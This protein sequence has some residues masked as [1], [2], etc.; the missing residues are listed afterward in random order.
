M[1]LTKLKTQLIKIGDLRPDKDNRES[2]DIDGLAGSLAQ[3]GL[4]NPIL[5]HRNVIVAGERRWRAA[6]QLKWS[7]IAARVIPDDTP[8]ETVEELRAVENLQRV[9]LSLWQEVDQLD[10]IIST[11][12]TERTL[13]DLATHLGK[14]PTWVAER[15]VLTK[16]LPDL[17]KLA[18]KYQWPAKAIILAA[19]M[20]TAVQSQ[21][22]SDVR[23]NDDLTVKDMQRAIA[24]YM[25]QL[26]TAPWDVNDA[27]LVK[28][29]GACSACPKR[30]SANQVL[31]PDMEKA[32]DDTC[33]D[34]KCWER[35]Q[36]ALIQ[37]NITKLEKEGTKP[38]LLGNRYEASQRLEN[39]AE[40]HGGIQSH[41]SYTVSEKPKPGFIPAVIVTGK[42]AGTQCYVAEPNK[43]SESKLDPETGK[44]K[45]KSVKQKVKVLEQKR[46][47]RTAELWREKMPKLVVSHP[48]TVIAV[49]LYGTER[50]HGTRGSTSPAA[51]AKMSR[52]GN[53]VRKRL[54]AWVAPVMQSRCVRFA[55]I[56]QQAELL[57]QEITS[58]AEL[59]QGERL[60]QDCW[61]QACEDVTMPKS[62]SKAG[63]KD[64]TKMPSL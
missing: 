39:Y 41:Y 18:E 28:E 6:K 48:L 52:D 20:P 25:R 16:A 5:V 13:E 61:K 36:A 62:L 24:R 55:P 38:V 22:L 14:T 53:E 9:D 50:N 12:K 56:E 51:I 3:I 11:S 40:K 60:L 19:R 1:N 63:A 27:E 44:P 34:A 10:K 32:K 23:H 31:F 4:M 47:C 54:W 57:W 29:A 58:Q 15:R 17:R 42:D 33:L 7:V 26:Q 45:P 35:K 8:R 37:L 46:M 43:I 21:V 59:L 64:N 30:S 49:S 2:T